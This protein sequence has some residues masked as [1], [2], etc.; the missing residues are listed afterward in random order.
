VST[1]TA[2]RF[3][4]QW[5]AERFRVHGIECQQAAAPKSDLYKD[6]LS[7]INSGIVELLDHAKGIAQIC[8]LERRTARGGRDSIDHPPGAHD[9]VANAIAGAVCGA[10]I[11]TGGAEGWIEYYRRLSEGHNLNTDVDDIRAPS[12]GYS[13]SSETWTTLEVPAVIAAGGFVR[14]AGADYGLRRFGTR[15]T[16]DLTRAGAIELLKHPVWRELNKALANELIGE[17]T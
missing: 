13:F 8:A 17:T 15:A 6:L 5:V 11:A 9:D 10:A 2:D 3:A 16:V 1:V 7:V 12:F 4:G 14:Y